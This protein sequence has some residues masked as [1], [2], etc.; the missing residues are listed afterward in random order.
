MLMQRTSKMTK[1]SDGLKMGGLFWQMIA[2]GVA[3]C[4]TWFWLFIKNMLEPEGFW[5]EALV[6]GVGIYVLG[7]IQ[8]V[9][10]VA[11]VVFSIFMWSK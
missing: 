9:L 3:G 7:T 10:L 8:L 1:R 4:P 2:I 6:Y 11:L 5:Q